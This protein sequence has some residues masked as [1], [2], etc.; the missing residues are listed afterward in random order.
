MNGRVEGVVVYR[1]LTED[2]RNSKEEPEETTNDEK[3][4]KG[5]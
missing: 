5:L 3:W 1:D 4:V 2:E